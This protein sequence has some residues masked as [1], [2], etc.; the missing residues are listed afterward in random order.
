LLGVDTASQ[1]LGGH[2]ARLGLLS[3][4]RAADSTARWAAIGEAVRA[5]ESEAIPRAIAAGL[6]GIVATVA[7]WLRR[8]E[9]DLN[10][11]VAVSSSLAAL[12]PEDRRIAADM[13][14]FE[15]YVER[16]RKTAERVRSSGAVRI[17][18]SLAYG[19]LSGLSRELTEKLERVRPDT[20]ERASRI[21]GM[22][23]AALA[24]LAVHI[25]NARVGLAG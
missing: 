15:G 11:V 24:L 23:P 4:S 25:E 16:Q 1:R 13:V 9:A 20:L 12:S 21:D 2:G 3:A 17:P 6:G 19:G 5:F 7:E 18:A 14:R 10:Q 22:T 8:P